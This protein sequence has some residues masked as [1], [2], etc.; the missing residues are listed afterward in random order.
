MSYL[1]KPSGD[2]SD[3]QERLLVR[4]VLQGEPWESV[5]AGLDY[6]S[7]SQCMRE[8]GTIARAVCETFGGAAAAAE[9]E[10]YS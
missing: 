6:A 3:R 10:R 5:A 7:T 9:R 1:L 4:K 8:M 2:L